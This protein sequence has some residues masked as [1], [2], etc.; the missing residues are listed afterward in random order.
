MDVRLAVA[1]SFSV[2]ALHTHDVNLGSRSETMSTRKALGPE[3]LLE[4]CLRNLESGRETKERD[5]MAGFRESVHNNR[6]SGETI[7]RGEISDN[8]YGQMGLRL[9]RHGKGKEFPCW[10]MPGRFSLRT[11]GAGVDRVG[12][13]LRQGGT[14]VLSGDGLNGA[15]DTWVSSSE[16]CVRPG[17]QPLSYTRGNVDALRGAGNRCRFPLQSLVDVE[18]QG[19]GKQGLRHPDAEAVILILR[20][21]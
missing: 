18:P 16:G 6:N 13:V 12:N 4:Q 19:K 8:V 9:L 21:G 11:Y 14:P 5:K 17:Q 20:P 1:P 10:S 2:K 7:R 3:H 15:G